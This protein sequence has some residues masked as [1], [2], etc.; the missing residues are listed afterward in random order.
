MPDPGNSDP[1]LRTDE[2]TSPGVARV[3]RE[4][5][6]PG[7][8][9]TVRI[10]DDRSAALGG[11]VG[12][13]VSVYTRFSRHRGTV[14]AGGLAF[15]G[16]L[17]VVPGVISMASLAALFVDPAQLAD[18][19]QQVAVHHP[20]G[21]TLVDALISQLDK[22]DATT[23]G[24]LGVAG[25]VS[26]GIAIYA[27]SRFVYVGRQVLDIAFDQ[28]Q[29]PPSLLTKVFAVGVTLLAQLAVALGLVMLTLV[30]TILD[31]LGIGSLYS[32]TAGHLRIPI[33][34]LS[35]YL[36][37]TLALRYGTKVRRVVGWASL[38][39]LVGTCVILVG[40]LGLGWYL[41]RS[42]TY[43]EIISALG[44][45]VALQLWLYLIGLAI[46]FAAETEAVRHRLGPSNT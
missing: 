32:A 9:R 1:A 27:A 17:S 3:V 21:Q 22:V 23:V 31:A 44:G 33:A 11:L 5:A 39:A 12:F 43:S 38:G 10:I 16:F 4:G 29:R 15:F 26:I 13:W 28:A 34:V 7:L 30:P 41:S 6:S 25:L 20:E 37:L 45:V 42:A 14:L 46:V 8:T 24:A 35:V 18:E 19:L 2:T 36:V 40:T